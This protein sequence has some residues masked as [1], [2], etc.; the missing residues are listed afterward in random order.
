MEQKVLEFLTDTEVTKRIKEQ[1]QYD[2]MKYSKRNVQ[3][4][5]AGIYF[6]EETKNDGTYW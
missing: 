1:A 6:M 2:I 3:S 4:E 5:L